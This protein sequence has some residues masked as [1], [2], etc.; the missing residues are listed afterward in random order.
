MDATF[1]KV[2]Q[3]VDVHHVNSPKGAAVNCVAAAV[4][5][6]TE[7]S[8]LQRKQIKEFYDSDV[9]PGPTASFELNADSDFEAKEHISVH[10]DVRCCHYCHIIKSQMSTCAKCRH[11][12]CALAPAS[13]KSRENPTQLGS[14]Q[15]TMPAHNPACACHI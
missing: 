14:L 5:L 10:F 15:P 11:A 1:S 2:L 13:N 3:Q 4:K 6:Y 8:A 12:W 9:A 7:S